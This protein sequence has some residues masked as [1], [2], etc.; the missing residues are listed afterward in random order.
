ML[1]KDP[2]V[3]AVVLGLDP[4][5]PAMLT[6]EG[7]EKE[8]YS[9]SNPDSIAESLPLLCENAEKPII[10]IVDGGRLYDPLV[11]LLISKDVVVFRSS[12]RAVQVLAMYMEGRL[13]GD[14]M[15]SRHRLIGE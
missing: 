15:L 2:G 3:D 1:L 5:S 13:Y 14:K 12:D 7:D 9:F 11:D 4:L 6:L 8:P 10:G